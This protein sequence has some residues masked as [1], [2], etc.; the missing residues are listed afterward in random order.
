MNAGNFDTW[1][2]GS[3]ITF[4]DD[5]AP[6]SVRI[7]PGTNVMLAFFDR[8]IGLDKELPRGASFLMKP[9]NA[10][11]LARKVRNAIDSAPA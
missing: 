3:N 11:T 5:R 8:A 2:M 6:R 7:P 10:D 1:K 4:R 9:F